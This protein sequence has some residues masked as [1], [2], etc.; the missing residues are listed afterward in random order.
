M[1][2][3]EASA[4][5]A[6]GRI[7]EV[8]GLCQA[9]LP[10]RDQLVRVVIGALARS[11]GLCPDLQK[12]RT[13]RHYRMK[14]HTTPTIHPGAVHDRWERLNYVLMPEQIPSRL[15]MAMVYLGLCV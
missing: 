6:V 3:H 7:A 4:P 8:A 14:L 2:G 15:A 13:L 12:S 5:A 9:R 1:G 10:G 11:L